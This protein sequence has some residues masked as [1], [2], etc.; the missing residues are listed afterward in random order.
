MIHLSSPPFEPSKTTEGEGQSTKRH[1]TQ[2]SGAA[3]CGRGIQFTLRQCLLGPHAE[4]SIFNSTRSSVQPSRNDRQGNGRLQEYVHCSECLVHA[5]P[6]LPGVLEA[7]FGV[8]TVTGSDAAPVSFSRHREI[9]VQPKIHESGS[10]LRYGILGP[11]FLRGL[12]AVKGGPCWRRISYASNYKGLVQFF[13]PPGCY[14]YRA[15]HLPPGNLW[16]YKYPLQSGI[17]SHQ[18]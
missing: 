4:R 6:R 17:Q 1:E 7:L 8:H 14:E 18:H 3:T 9:L 16:W 10:K 11:A 12:S 15:P 5:R 13:F 2:T